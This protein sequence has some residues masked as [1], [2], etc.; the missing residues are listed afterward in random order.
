MTKISQQMVKVRER[1]TGTK[2]DIAENNKPLK[3]G[4]KWHIRI[5]W[6]ILHIM[7]AIKLI[8]LTEFVQILRPSSREIF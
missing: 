2:H 8:P 7:F 6:H 1:N 5:F 4:S 3:V